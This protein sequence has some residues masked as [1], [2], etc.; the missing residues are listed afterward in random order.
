MIAA[1]VVKFKT[2]AARFA[3]NNSGAT[4]IEYGLIA[5]LMA[6]ACIGAF[7]AL[8]NSNNGSWGA[9]AKKVAAAMQK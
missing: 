2:L 3:R 1:N 4:A 7:S 6:V 8:G 9:M 5:A